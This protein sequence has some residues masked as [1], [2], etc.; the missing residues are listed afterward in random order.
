MGIG[1]YD[2]AAGI[3]YLLEKQNSS[4]P[5]ISANL[6]DKNNNLYFPPYTIVSF[7]DRKIGIVG[8]SGSNFISNDPILT[9][10]WRDALPDHLENLKQQ[11]DFIL[12][13]STMSKKDNE[14]VAQRF[15]EINLIISSISSNGNLRPKRVNKTLITQTHSRGKYLGILNL[16]WSDERE[17]KHQDPKTKKVLPANTPGDYTSRFIPLSSKIKDRDDIK[18]KTDSLNSEI[19]KLNKKTKQQ[20][21][22]ARTQRVGM[23]LTPSNYVGSS[24]CYRCHT[25]Q[26]KQWQATK[27][28]AAIHT[29]EKQSQQ[30]NL[31]CLPCHVTSPIKMS[32]TADAKRM[33]LRLPKQLLSVGCESCHGGG[34]LH[35]QT[36][37]KSHDFTEITEDTCRKC[38][39]LEMDKEFSFD[40]LVQDVIHDNVLQ[41]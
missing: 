7:D 16:T 5:F 8:L 18:A 6:A 11:C 1:S 25:E 34:R 15:P 2:L 35:I 17:W 9:L 26:Y 40:L 3:D 22:I 32:D 29:L 27:H 39:S 14:L 12:L 33:L 4:S 13:L 10:N 37:G 19:A 28:S 38:H 24:V 30:N 31:N 36:K 23:P 21:P 20:R 41:H